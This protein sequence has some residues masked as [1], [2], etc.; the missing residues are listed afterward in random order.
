MPSARYNHS[1]L[2]YKNSLILFGGIEALNWEKNDAYLFNLDKKI[3]T[4]LQMHETKTLESK[5]HH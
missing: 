2:L 5:L 4:Q 1:L 3:W